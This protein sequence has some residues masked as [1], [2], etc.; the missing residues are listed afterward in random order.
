[1]S[2]LP[3]QR[4]PGGQWLPDVVDRRTLTE[5]ERR[6]VIA[7]ARVQ[8]ATFRTLGEAAGYSS[9]N[10]VVGVVE[11]LA[12]K[13]LVSRKKRSWADPT[14]NHSRSLRLTEGIVVSDA[15]LVGQFMELP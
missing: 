6:T 11:R 13:G 1:M 2:A 15:G 8:P 5:P 9:T 10:G 4:R 7:L 14:I 12:A 3:I